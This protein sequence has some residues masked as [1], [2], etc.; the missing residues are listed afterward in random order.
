MKTDSIIKPI[1]N[2]NYYY[3]TIV[4]T[5]IIVGKLGLRLIHFTT[6]STRFIYLYNCISFYSFRRMRYEHTIRSILN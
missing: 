5:A 1:N 6:I 4:I 3:F 2:N